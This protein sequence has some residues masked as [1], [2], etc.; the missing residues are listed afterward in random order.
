LTRR[1]VDVAQDV[2]IRETDC[3]TDRGLEI[4]AIKEGNEVIETLEERLLGRYTRKTV[5]DPRDG[6]VII[7]NN[8]IIAEDIVF[9][10]SG[11]RR[12][13]TEDDGE[14][15]HKYSYEE[16]YHQEDIMPWER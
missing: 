12:L 9:L 7:K 3:G 4:M 5:F 1:L 15:N 14:N 8:E 6:S 10:D 11:K 13:K 16:N 2:I